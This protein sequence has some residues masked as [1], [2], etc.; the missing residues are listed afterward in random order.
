MKRIL[1]GILNDELAKFEAR[2]IGFVIMPDHVHALIWFPK[3]GQLSRFMQQWKG[4]SS[5]GIK[6]FLYCSLPEYASKI[7]RTDPIWQVR[8][9]SF[10]IYTTAKIEEKLNYMHLNPVRAGLVETPTR[11]RWGSARWYLERRTVGVPIQ[12]VD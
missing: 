11:W 2:C 10:E 12:R 3:T 4:R 9:Y 7:P 6:E 8:F 1:L 5:K